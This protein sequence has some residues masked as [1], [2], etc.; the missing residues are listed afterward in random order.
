LVACIELVLLV[1]MVEFDE[2]LTLR[3]LW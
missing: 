1:E 3:V 2:L